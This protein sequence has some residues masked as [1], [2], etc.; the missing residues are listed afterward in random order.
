MNNL[1]QAL[2]TLFMSPGASVTEAHEQFIQTLII[3]CL[4]E[5]TKKPVDLDVVHNTLVD[6]NKYATAFGE[7]QARNDDHTAAVFGAVDAYF[8][9][10]KASSPFT[11]LLTNAYIDAGYAE[12]MSLELMP[13]H[14]DMLDEFERDI[15]Q[16]FDGMS[17]SPVVPTVLHNCGLGNAML[18]QLAV[19]NK[20]RKEH[21]HKISVHIQDKALF[22]VLTA[23]A[24]ILVYLVAHPD[25]A[26]P[27][28]VSSHEAAEGEDAT[29]AN[30]A[31]M[32]VRK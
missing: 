20:E 1:T 32:A 29:D 25:A 26:I 6:L 11:D 30:L 15:L 28:S 23:F 27:H 13:P 24:Q 17:S 8:E 3:R 10:A 4:V 9:A 7:L 5:Q 16:A 2:N 18:K 22:A 12:A 31:L 19:L 14:D 21:M